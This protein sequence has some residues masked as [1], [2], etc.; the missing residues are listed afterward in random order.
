MNGESYPLHF[1]HMTTATVRCE[2]GD[3]KADAHDAAE[4]QSV[5]ADAAMHVAALGPPHRIHEH[6]S[7]DSTVSPVI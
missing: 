4:V 5:L 3:F 1:D 7:R 2:A 6:V